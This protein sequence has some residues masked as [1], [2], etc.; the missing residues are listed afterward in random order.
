MLVHERAADRALVL[1]AGIRPEWVPRGV[2]ARRL[3]TK[4][5]VVSFTLRAEGT[6]A[7]RVRIAGDLAVPAG[8]IV[9]ANPLD[10]PIRRATLDGRPLAAG[11]DAVTIDRCPADLVLYYDQPPA[12]AAFDAPVG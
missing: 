10:R 1:G 3:P 11:D 2:S 7:V 6:D 5:G 12:A 8:G 4:S 9:V